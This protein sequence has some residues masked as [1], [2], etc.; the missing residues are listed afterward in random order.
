MPL[1]VVYFVIS[2]IQFLLRKTCRNPHLHWLM[3]NDVNWIWTM[4]WTKCMITSWIKALSRVSCKLFPFL[5]TVALLHC[6]HEQCV[7]SKALL[8]RGRGVTSV[9]LNELVLNKNVLLLAAYS[10][11]LRWLG[12]R[13][14]EWE[15]GG[16]EETRGL[17][18]FKLTH[19][20]LLW[21]LEALQSH[22]WPI[23]A[24]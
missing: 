4:I 3:T 18:C 17:Y 15:T 8:E 7:V 2:I 20:L 16:G 13:Q 11:L 14:R 23:D 19:T 24:S 5:R 12:K 6:A 10:G 9:S 1:I 22:K 21:P